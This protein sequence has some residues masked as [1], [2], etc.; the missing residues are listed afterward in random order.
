MDLGV[1]AIEKGGGLEI[2]RAARK[3]ARLFSKIDLKKEKKPLIGIVGEILSE[4]TKKAT[5]IGH[6]A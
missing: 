3:A 1:N 5:R 4:H 2:I 6:R